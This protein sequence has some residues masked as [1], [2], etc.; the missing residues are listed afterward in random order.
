M[1]SSIHDL[2]AAL[3]PLRQ[4]QQPQSPFP[5][6]N[7][8]PVPNNA[9]EPETDEDDDNVTRPTAGGSSEERTLRALVIVS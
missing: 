7:V 2:I 9:E 3:N 8:P 6:P 4:N 5:V 1:E